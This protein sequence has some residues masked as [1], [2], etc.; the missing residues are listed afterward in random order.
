MTLAMANDT[1]STL[2][3]LHPRPIHSSI[4]ALECNLFNK[5]QV[6]QSS[7]SEER[8]F[9]GLAEQPAEYALKSATPWTNGPNLRPHHP[10]G[11][12]VQL[13]WDA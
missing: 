11:L 10:V 3:L 1:I 8:G 12:N 9:R 7:Q 13:T 2:L 4:G 5:L 6:I